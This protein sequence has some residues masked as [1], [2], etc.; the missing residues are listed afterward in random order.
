MPPQTQLSQDEFKARSIELAER[1]YRLKDR[2]E[3]FEASKI[4]E[5]VGDELILVDQQDRFYKAQSFLEAM[6][7]WAEDVRSLAHEINEMDKMVY[8]TPDLNFDQCLQLLTDVS[9]SYLESPATQVNEFGSKLREL[10]AKF[11]TPEVHDDLGTSLDLL[12]DMI[13][14]LLI[15]IHKSAKPEVPH[16]VRLLRSIRD[17]IIIKRQLSVDQGKLV[18]LEDQDVTQEMRVRASQEALAEVY[19]K[20]SSIIP[21]T[22]Q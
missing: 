17:S 18:K 12:L 13:E 16:N 3:D 10:L 8:A 9:T 19:D 22:P 5:Q 2:S 6:T 1:A 20:L 7:A 15:N 21:K 11:S 14:D 4:L